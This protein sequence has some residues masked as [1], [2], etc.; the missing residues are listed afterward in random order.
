MT[1]FMNLFGGSTRLTSNYSNGAV[2]FVLP[3]LLGRD[4][5]HSARCGANTMRH[6]RMIVLWGANILET[7]WARTLIEASRPRP[8]VVIRTSAAPSRPNGPTPGGFPAGP[9]PTRP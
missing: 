3:Y 4:S 9:V 6:S 8:I 2:A 1:R 5:A 7:T